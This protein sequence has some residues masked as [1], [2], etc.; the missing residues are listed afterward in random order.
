MHFGNDRLV[1]RLLLVVLS[2]PSLVDAILGA[3]GTWSRVQG[4][5]ATTPA[6]AAAAQGQTAATAHHQQH[7]FGHGSPRTS[8]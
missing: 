1:G 2:V 6:T 5:A 3:S 8:Q 7:V 4:A